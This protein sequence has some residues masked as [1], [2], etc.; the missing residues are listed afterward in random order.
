MWERWDG[1]VVG[2]GFRFWRIHSF[3]NYAYGSVGE[4]L[5]CVI[6][7]IN[8][9]ETRLGYEHF[10]IYPQPKHPLMWA[11]GH[12]DTIQESKRIRLEG[13]NSNL[14]RIVLS[15]CKYAFH[16]FLPG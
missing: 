12:V 3:N 14:A 2:R 1:Y 9:D 16:S 6:L 15:S 10:S 8:P 7:G 5:Y 4:F 13:W 11:K